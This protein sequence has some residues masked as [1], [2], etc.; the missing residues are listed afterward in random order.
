MMVAAAQQQWKRQQSCWRP[1]THSNKQTN[2]QAGFIPEPKNLMLS[3]VLF[4][5]FPSLEQ[6][7]QHW[8][9]G[10]QAEVAANMKI[11][12]KLM[13]PESNKQTAIW[14]IIAVFKPGP[15]N[16]MLSLVLFTL[17]PSLERR[18]WWWRRQWKQQR[19]CWR[20]LKPTNKQTNKLTSDLNLKTLCFSHSSHLWNDV[21]NSGSAAMIKRRRSWRQTSKQTNSMLVQTWT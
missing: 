5:L 8:R 9:H 20:P 12:M 14:Y 4:T 11:M 19:S 15:K 7:Q 1:L 13:N 10:A 17:F 6:R 3:L 21:N 18:Q 2:I 16:L